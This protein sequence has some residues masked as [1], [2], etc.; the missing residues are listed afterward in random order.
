MSALGGKVKNKGS[1]IDMAIEDN[2]GQAK[3]TWTPPHSNGDVFELLGTHFHW[4]SNDGIGSEHTYNE[5]SYAME[6]HV[7]TW[8]TKYGSFAEAAKYADGVAVVG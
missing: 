3:P 6:Q 4:G 5:R 7:V 8:N 1:T 2:N